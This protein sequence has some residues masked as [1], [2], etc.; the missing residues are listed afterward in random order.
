MSKVA[1]AKNTTAEILKG[2]IQSLVS[3]TKLPPKV[4]AESGK[5]EKP[6]RASYEL[7]RVTK[8]LNSTLAQLRLADEEVE[9]V[10]FDKTNTEKELRGQLESKDQAVAE[11]QRERN[12]SAVLLK[13]KDE[14]IAELEIK[15][16]TLQ[17]QPDEA[18]LERE[19]KLL[20]S[21][22]AELSNTLNFEVAEKG[23]LGDKLAI[24][25][26]SVESMREENDG[27]ITELKQA[28]SKLLGYTQLKR[29]LDEAQISKAQLSSK[30]EAA[31]KDKDEQAK[32]IQSLNEQ[33]SQSV[34]R[35]RSHFNEHKVPDLESERKAKELGALLDVQRLE[36]A[37]YSAEA[38][39]LSEELREIKC[40][41]VE[42]ITG[43]NER[44]RRKA[45]EAARLLSEEQDKVCEFK[46]NS[47]QFKVLQT[48]HDELLKANEEEKASWIVKEANLSKQVEDLTREK[49]EQKKKIDKL[50]EFKTILSNPAVLTGLHA[51]QNL[52]S[53][54][55]GLDGK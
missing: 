55:E 18:V 4:R 43:E 3:E 52:T 17:S 25:A 28:N 26:K 48:E 45:V 42:W 38:T 44:L 22:H 6:L 1:K 9:R 16:A 50:M 39:R 54:V 32:K 40:S 37:K 21:D 24:L 49:N 51:L 19:L 33:V 41:T 46:E 12:D 29:D 15:L 5:S 34:L 31:L 8:E 27:L 10:W 7:D 14:W 20:R 23:K 11:L 30:L 47:D 35:L 13:A 36:T 2:Q 53:T